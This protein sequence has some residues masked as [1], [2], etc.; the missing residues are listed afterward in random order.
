[1][2]VLKCEIIAVGNELLFGD[3]LNTNANFLSKEIFNLGI[4]VTK[5]TAVGDNVDD[6][7]LALDVARKS[8]DIIILSGGLGPTDDDL[9]KETLT[10][11]IGDK[12]VVDDESLELINEF[13]KSRNRTMSDNNKKQAFRPATGICLQNE[14]GT[15]PGIYV[16]KD[17]VHYFLL[18]GPPRQ[19]KP[20]FYNRAVPILKELS[21]KVIYSKTISVTGIGESSA[22]SM[23]GD[24]LTNDANPMVAP[25]AKPGTVNF[26]ITAYASDMDS[27]KKLVADKRREL[28]S[29]LKDYIF[30]EERETLEEVI[31]KEMKKA[32]KTLSI[33][34]SCTGGMVASR[35]VGVSGASSVFKSGFITYSNESKTKFLDVKEE[36]IKKFGAVSEECALEM[37][38]G[39]MKSA[40]S[41]YGLS[42]TGI[43]GPTGGTEEKPVGTVFICVCSKDGHQITKY[44]MPGDRNK[45][46]KY[47]SASALNQ[48]YKFMK[49]DI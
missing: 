30:S 33:A 39:A 45:V 13:F 44:N 40:A 7:K 24:L 43:A 14:Q 42:V 21:N 37:A 28:H 17:A 47:S 15:A 16:K 29:V 23:L 12:L 5:H 19:L 31:I 10:D 8:N 38:K 2:D 3:T 1:M 22:A 36:T 27:A 18:P 26:K 34:E 49:K 48:L 20:M 11:F 41:D 32:G 6:L 9:T 25:Y 46:R 35:V 4:S